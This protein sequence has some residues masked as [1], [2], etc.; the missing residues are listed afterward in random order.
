MLLTESLKTTANFITQF[1]RS[2]RTVGA[3]APSTP[4]L[5]R[6]MVS[7]ADWAYSRRVAEFGADTGVLTHHI[8]RHMR[9]DARLDI[10]ETNPHFCQALRN[11]ADRRTAVHCASAAAITQKYDAIFSGLPLLAFPQALRQTILAQAAHALTPDGV[12]IQFQY[13]SLLEDSLS[14]HFLW[15]RTLVWRNLPPAFVYLCR[16]RTMRG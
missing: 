15:Q 2:P 5:C 8:Q 7:S 6:Q 16:A 14:A 9:A 13:S 11:I 10:F 4:Y 3:I 12:F 1:V